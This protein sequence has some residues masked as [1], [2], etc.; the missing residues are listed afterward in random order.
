MKANM[1]E[2]FTEREWKY[3]RMLHRLYET[4]EKTDKISIS[5]FCK[6]NKMTSIVSTV[7]YNGGL[8]KSE[9]NRRNQIVKW[10]THRPNIH[11][12]RKLIEEV[13]KYQGRAYEK[14]KKRADR[15]VELSERK[16][17]VASIEAASIDA[18]KWVDNVNTN[19]VI[20]KT[21]KSSGIVDAKDYYK[22]D[23]RIPV[24]HGVFTVLFS[25][26][27]DLD[28]SSVPEYDLVDPSGDNV[29]NFGHYR[30]VNV[31]FN[32]TLVHGF[33]I[34]F[35]L[36]NKWAKVNHGV[37]AHEVFHAASQLMRYRDTKHSVKTE[38]TY[39]YIIQ[40]MTD[41][42]YEVIEKYGIEIG[43]EF[44]RLCLDPA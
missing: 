26:V 13:Q 44:D 40:W 3:L 38:E 6:E 41:R 10:N 29:V 30:D 27:D 4:L 35:N 22:E 17:E 18:V 23:F 20:E 1:K 2:E 25:N 15:A 7:I 42:V 34:Q 9:G 8:I 24:F 33:G 19:E 16:P 36:V 21:V 5:Q 12:A 43:T 28:L 39:A 14:V 31:N 37:I 11:M 32:G